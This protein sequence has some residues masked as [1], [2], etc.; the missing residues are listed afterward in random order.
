[1]IENAQKKSNLIWSPDNKQKDALR[2]FVLTFG[3]Q[4]NEYDSAK[5]IAVMEKAY[6][7]VT[8]PDP[9]NADLIIL[10]T[11]SVRAKA[12]EKLFSELGRIK[13]LKIKRPSLVIGVGGCVASQEKE[14]ILKRAPYVD[15]V[16]GPQTIHRLPQMYAEVIKKSFKRD[17]LVDTSFPQIEKFDYFPDPHADGPSAFVSI[18]EGCN[19]FC[20]Y[21]IVPYTR[22]REISRP[23]ADIIAEVGCLAEQGV[24]E[25][26]LLGQN[27]NAYRFGIDG[28]TVTLADLI[29]EIAKISAIER[30]RFTT[31]HPAEFSDDLIAVFAQE[32]KLVSHLHLPVQ[33][34]SNKILKLMRRGYTAEE[35]YE[36]IA[37][38]RRVRPNISISSDF[39]VG[40]PGESEE[41]FQD[42]MDLITKVNFDASFSFIYSPRPN[43][44][45]AELE[46]NVTKQVK[47]Q[48]LMRLQ[49]QIG[50]QARAIGKGMIGT[51]QLI[52]VTGKAKRG[53][54][55]YTGRTENNR[56]VNFSADKNH[57]GTMR[58]VRIIEAL[59]NSLRAIDC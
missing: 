50:A 30:I 3:C 27:V 47:K 2:I 52:L 10:N 51:D 22:G 13:S 25:I 4:M 11:C 53:N 43:T 41:D 33:S 17:K 12:E 9:T 56:V 7:F 1:M 32:P 16:F 42:T 23:M 49:N 26:N 24:K 44:P 6:G 59:P 35:Y 31:S 45:A 40:F 55:Q 54:N 34:G 39:I 20:S 21:C 58:T 48:R 14:N 38:L 37:Q 36:K 29:V 57:V 28:A 19:K 5:I 15:I 8:T 18:M 46:D